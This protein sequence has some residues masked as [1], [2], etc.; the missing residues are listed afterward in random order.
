MVN[1]VLQPHDNKWKVILNAWKA[2]G[3]REAIDKFYDTLPEL[4]PFQDIDPLMSTGQPVNE[5]NV[6]AY[7]EMSEEEWQLHGYWPRESD[8]DTDDEVFEL[9]WNFLDAFNWFE[10]L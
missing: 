9:E 10:L 3:I 5:S 2:S 4:E 8:E 6:A 7:L 1:G